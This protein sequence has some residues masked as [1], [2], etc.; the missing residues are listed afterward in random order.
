[1]KFITILAG[2]QAARL[3][4]WDAR[5]TRAGDRLLRWLAGRGASETAIQLGFAGLVG[6][7]AGAAVLVFYRAIDVA[8]GWGTRFYESVS[9]LTGLWYVGQVA[10]LGA[11]LAV[12]GWIVRHWAGGSPGENIP[13]V[14][15]AVARRGGVVHLTPVTAKTAGAAVTLAVGGSVG[16]EGPVAVLGAA[17]GSRLGRWTRAA[18]DRLRMLVACGAAAG[19]AGAFGAPLAGVFFA[20][21]K[22]IAGARGT[23]LAPVV[24]A[25][26]AAAAVTRNGL[27]SAPVIAIPTVYEVELARDLALYA[28]VGLLGGLVGV[29]YT[30]V[31]WAAHDLLGRWPLKVRVAVAALM[32]AALASLFEPA[33]WGSGHQRLDL[34]LAAAAPWWGLLL[35]A[36]A[37]LFCTA[38]TLAGGGVGGVFTPALVI[39]GA[40][41]AGVAAAVA[42]VWPGWTLAPVAVGL[43]GMAAVVSGSM[44]APLTAVFMVVEMTGDYGLVLPLLL[45]SALA[46]VV[47]R[48]LHHESIY[49]EWLVRRGEHVSHG[50]DEAELSRLRV[51]AALRRNPLTLRADSPL[52]PAV[53]VAAASPQPLVPVL[54]R[55]GI[56]TGLVS[57]DDLRRGMRTGARTVAEVARPVEETVA[58][59]DSLLVA[60][61]RLGLRD[62]PLLP[63]LHRS[64]TLD[65]VVGRSDILAAYDR[66]VEEGVG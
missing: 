35:L 13:D 36:A 39:G 24:V 46:L 27:G 8:A 18:P 30:R 32:V 34:G 14:M 11:G 28:G 29:G 54:D 2:E 17:V 3:R 20:L 56:V 43:V 37:K 16:A 38:L 60:L 23:A 9:H 48:R 42:S 15:D 25:C 7:F 1:M 10:V 21:E 57:W 44:H 61:R 6:G 64:G 12:V 62:A 40:F 51:A 55:N 5:L 33:L 45:G 50:V 31:V 41:G 66:R 65:G 47:A 58:A 4:R 59:D 19:I 49:T 53:A 22:L 52:R 63:V 26:A